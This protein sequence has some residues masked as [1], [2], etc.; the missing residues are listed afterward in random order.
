[1]VAEK[2]IQTFSAFEGSVAG[3]TIKGISLIQ[4]GPAI[5][6]GVWV[7]STTLS[8]VRKAA[9]S[10]G[11]VKAKLNHWSGIQD[12]VG[13]Y[14]N[15]RLR[16]G[17]LIADLTLFESH[18]GKDALLEMIETIP[19][20]FGV[21]IMFAAESPEYDK[22]HDRYNT[23]VRELYSA[24]FVDTPAANRDGVFN[25]KIDKPQNDMAN[26]NHP[27]T[28]PDAFDAKAAIA[29]L[30]SQVAELTKALAAKAEEPVEEPPVEEKPQETALSAEVAELKA[31]L[32]AFVAAPPTK[33]EP[34][35]A[36]EQEAP[37]APPKSY[38]EAR[39]EAIGANTGLQRIAAARAFDEKFADEAAY[40]ASFSK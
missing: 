11:R 8:Q 23:R 30:E 7:D 9:V 5:G 40:L 25:A 19:N 2:E 1:M 16:G 4:E 37:P 13:F 35:P 22:K 18:Q 24:D 15:F 3:N 20:A 21:S 26:A 10:M 12:T 34:A 31:M 32:K 28:Q 39:K 6:H 17:K 36:N 14:D 29:A 27:D 38:A 33:Q